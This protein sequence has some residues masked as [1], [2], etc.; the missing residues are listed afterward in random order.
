MTREQIEQ[1][2]NDLEREE[3]LLSMKDHWTREDWETDRQRTA[4]LRELNARL[5]EM[6]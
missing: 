1:R 3:F 4:E 2:I 5:M 6:R